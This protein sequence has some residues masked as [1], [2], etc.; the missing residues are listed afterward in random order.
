ML[1]LCQFYLTL[2]ELQ[3]VTSG[4][5]S[6]PSS[7]T[8]EQGQCSTV[9]LLMSALLRQSTLHHCMNTSRTVL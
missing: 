4:A 9:Q 6:Q 5:E 3:D 1:L 8:L 7:G 2:P